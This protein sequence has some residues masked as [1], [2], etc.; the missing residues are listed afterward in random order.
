MKAKFVGDPS[1]PNEAVPDS[2]EVYGLTFEKGKATE[3]P[4]E[5]EAKFVGNNHFETTGKEH[6]E[7]KK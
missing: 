2:I 6:D 1:Q 5:L 4:E 7:A 3:I